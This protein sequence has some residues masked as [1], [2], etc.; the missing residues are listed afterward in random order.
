MRKNGYTLIEILV[1]IAI[2]L[3]LAGAIFTLYTT[4]IKENMSKSLIAKKESD[5]KILIYQLL[6]DLEGI[7]FGVDKSRL[8]I[9]SEING[10]NSSDLDNVLTITDTKDPNDENKIIKIIFLNLSARD[11]QYSGCWG[12]GDITGNLNISLSK[13]YL[14]R[15]CPSLNNKFLF[16]DSNKNYKFIETYQNPNIKYANLV[17]FYVGDKSYPDNFKVT[18]FLKIPNENEDK[19]ILPKECMQWKKEGTQNIPGTGTYSLYREVNGDTAQPVASCIHTLK[20]RYGK[21]DGSYADSV[22]SIDEL[23]SVVVCMLIQVGGKQST[24]EDVP[25]F[26]TDKCS[27]LNNDIDNAVANNPDMR[28]YRWATIEEEVILKNIR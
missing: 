9:N 17:A 20:F 28:Y 27:N 13:N 2:S 6:K 10:G 16:L 3:I 5:A 14:S 12:Y 23:S 11:E 24:Q 8:K 19:N 7:G 4:I 1:V 26:K 18:Y 15:D 21:S 22:N 25:H